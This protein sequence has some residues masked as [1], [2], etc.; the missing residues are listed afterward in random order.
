MPFAQAEPGGI[1][2]ETL[3]PISLELVHNGHL[4]LPQ[5]VPAAVEHAGALVRP[6]RRQARQ[7]RAGRPRACSTPTT[8]GRSIAPNSGAR[9][10]TRRSTSGRCRAASWPP[11]SAAAPSIAT[12]AFA[13]TAARPDAAARRPKAASKRPFRLLWSCLPRIRALHDASTVSSSRRRRRWRSRATAAAPAARPVARRPARRASPAT[14]RSAARSP[15]TPGAARL[16]RPPADPGR[17]RAAPSQPTPTPMPTPTPAAGARRRR[18][19]ADHGRAT[20]GLVDQ[21]SAPLTPQPLGVPG[22]GIGDPGRRRRRGAPPPADAGSQR[23]LRSAQPRR[24]RPPEA[25]GAQAAAA[26]APHRAAARSLT[27]STPQPLVT[28]RRRQPDLRRFALLAGH[29]RRSP[30]TRRSRVN[31]QAR[32]HLH[33]CRPAG[34]DGLSRAGDRSSRASRS[35]PS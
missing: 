33:E 17:R 27:S 4:T 2:L 8:P 14:S 16:L 21:R 5:P 12:T 1:G 15:T 6:A 26:A 35:P 24:Y 28:L 3:L 10:R 19:R 23:R 9:P 11:S 31:T 18:R 25:I 32:V 22:G 20:D 30:P 13:T 7:G 29:G 34:R